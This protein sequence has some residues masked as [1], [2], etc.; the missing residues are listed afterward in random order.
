MRFVNF[1][2]LRFMVFA[3]AVKFM[4]SVRKEHRKERAESVFCQVVNVLASAFRKEC[5]HQKRQD[6]SPLLSQTSISL[7]N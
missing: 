7:I 3:I 5:T 1:P 2:T 4:Q 6:N